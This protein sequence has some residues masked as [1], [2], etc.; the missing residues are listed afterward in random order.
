MLD[1]WFEDE[2]LPRLKGRAFLVRFADD[3]VLVFAREDDARRVLEVLPKRLERFGLE[4]HPDKTRLV[5]Y[6]RPARPH[7]TQPA[8]RSG[9]F[10][11]L[12]FTHYWGLSRNGRRVV[13]R[14]TAKGRLKRAIHTIDQWCR[15]VRHFKIRI[16]HAGLLRK[17]RGHYNYY[18]IN[19]NIDC[20]EQFRTAVARSWKKWLNRRSQNRHV[21]WERFNEILAIYPLPQPT[22]RHS[23]V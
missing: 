13:K 10:Q 6:R 21:N 12:G 20:L 22:T 18:G 14:R 11:F 2:I 7:G 19:G 15:K 17:L 4:L 8:P 5:D 3:A 9:S 23:G 16:Q 1:C